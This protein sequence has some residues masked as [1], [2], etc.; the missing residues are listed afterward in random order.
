MLHY[1]LIHYNLYSKTLTRE[2]CTSLD[3]WYRRAFRARREDTCCF[4]RFEYAKGFLK[5]NNNIIHSLS[6]SDPC[7]IPW[8]RSHQNQNHQ[9][10]NHS[11][12][13]CLVH[14]KSAQTFCHNIKAAIT[15][16]N[17]LG[18]IVSHI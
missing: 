8:A 15:I 18:I 14:T 3:G 12:L 9:N 10:Q 7:M 11:M 16:E 17:S 1:V 4:I 13:V 5:S 2:W 6:S